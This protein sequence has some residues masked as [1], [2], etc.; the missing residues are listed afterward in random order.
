[1]T[2][3]EIRHNR[4]ADEMLQAEQRGCRA[5]T[6]L[7]T[8]EAAANWDE[9]MDECSQTDRQATHVLTC[10]ALCLQHS[11]LSCPCDA[12]FRKV[13]TATTLHRP[14]SIADFTCK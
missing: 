8:L 9:Q 13:G 14:L 3:Q 1:M 5:A 10:T 7:L 11:E 4:S 6:E 2:M 12:H